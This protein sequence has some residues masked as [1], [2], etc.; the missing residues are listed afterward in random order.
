MHIEKNA[1][2]I[3]ID[4]QKGF[5]QPLVWGRRNNPRAERNIV[6]LCDLWQDTGRPI[7]CVRHTADRALS[8]FAPWLPF[9]GLKS[10]IVH[11][12]FNV[13]ID[14]TVNSG[15]LGTPD[16][17]QW[18]QSSLVH[19]IVVV[20]IQTNMC[21][22]TTARMGANL[23]YDVVVPLDA[24]HTFDLKVRGRTFSAD[25]LTETTAANLVGGGFARVVA[26]SEL[27]G[28]FVGSSE[29]GCI[30]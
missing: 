25:E 21:V 23:G 17:G 7:V 13:T 29:S 26:T 12:R 8:P 24:T 15:F 11:V 10:E 3:V 27:L 22:E 16:L 14:K 30:P 20:G 5:N 4:V 18:L 9:R 6:A 2:L 19:Q 28:G 1:A